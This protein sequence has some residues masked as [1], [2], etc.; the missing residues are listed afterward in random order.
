MRIA[1]RPLVI[2]L[3][4]IAL[5]SMLAAGFAVFTVGGAHAAALSGQI[6]HLT[7]VGSSSFASAPPATDQSTQANEI[8]AATLG[9][10]ADANDGGGDDSDSGINRTPLGAKTGHGKTISSSARAKSNP[11]LGA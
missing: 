11:T 4:G 1:K 3:S 7:R 8:D 9:N 10:D 5:V 6:V 2:A